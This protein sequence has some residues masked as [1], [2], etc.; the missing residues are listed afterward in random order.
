[1]DNNFKHKNHKFSVH[2]GISS[3]TFLQY[4]TDLTR[5]VYV[6]VIQVRY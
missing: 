5:Q 1:M 6:K 3:Q 4:P 2:A